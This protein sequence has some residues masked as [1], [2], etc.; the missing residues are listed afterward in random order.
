[1]S[2]VAMSDAPARKSAPSFE[3]KLARLVAETGLDNWDDDGGRA[4][5]A[6]RWDLIREIVTKVRAR[7]PGVPDPYPSAGGDG[8]RHLRW[9]R[10]DLLFDVDFAAEGPTLWTR[11]VGKDMTSGAT[12]SMAELVEQLE[13]TFT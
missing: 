3:T 10:S 5:P 12:A 7:L 4:I 11:R 2:N 9:V 6:Q 8:S 13:K 1:V